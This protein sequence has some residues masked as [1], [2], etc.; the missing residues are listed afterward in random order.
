MKKLIVAISMLA[1][2]ATGQLSVASSADQ[3]PIKLLTAYEAGKVKLSINEPQLQY[4]EEVTIGSKGNPLKVDVDLILTEDDSLAILC[5]LDRQK[6]RAFSPDRG[7]VG[8]PREN[9]LLLSGI[10]G[11]VYMEV[12]GFAYHKHKALVIAIIDENSFASLLEVRTQDR[13]WLPKFLGFLN[14]NK[15][16]FI[17]GT[18]IIPVAWF[19]WRRKSRQSDYDYD[20]Y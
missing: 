20:L 1:L 2:L 12:E 14:N 9:G 15:F 6:I 13:G 8:E 7:L 19:L 18:L 16:W 11:V 10:E 5:G 3:G 17:A 4:Y